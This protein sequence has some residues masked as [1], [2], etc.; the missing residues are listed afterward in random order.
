MF[1][2]FRVSVDF[3]GCLWVSGWLPVYIGVIGADQYIWV[4]YRVY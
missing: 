3:S 1:M 2:G 4:Y